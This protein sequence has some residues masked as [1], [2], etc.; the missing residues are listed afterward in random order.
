V[1]SVRPGSNTLRKL[2]PIQNQNLDSPVS[3]DENI[4]GFRSRW[5]TIPFR[6]P[7]ASPWPICTPYSMVLRW[8]GALVQVYPQAFARQKLQNQNGV[9]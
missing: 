4:L 5:T 7:A 3:G 8:E 6:A 1:S 2:R 9:P